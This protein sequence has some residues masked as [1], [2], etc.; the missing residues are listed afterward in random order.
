MMLLEHLME[1]KRWKQEQ[2]HDKKRDL[3]EWEL[4]EIEQTIQRVF[5]QQKLV[6][7]TLC[8]RNKLN[9]EVGIVTVLM[10]QN[11]ITTSYRSINKTYNL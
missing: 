11:G 1:I 7:L 10:L 6:K 2:Y 8:N 3:T 4:E 9:D 5:K